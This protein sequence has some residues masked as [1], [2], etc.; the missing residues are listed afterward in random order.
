MESTARVNAKQ[1]HTTTSEGGD[2]FLSTYQRDPVNTLLP[3][4]S[5][6][7]KRFSHSILHTSIKA[8][9]F[10]GP[11]RLEKI[12]VFINRWENTPHT[13]T[14]TRAGRKDR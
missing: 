5:S 9:F 2:L 14:D 13:H 4:Y 6:E 3:S 12:N 8:G 1:N 7:L 11:Q 10:L